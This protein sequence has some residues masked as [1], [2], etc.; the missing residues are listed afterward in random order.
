MLL[1]VGCGTTIDDR[2]R[3]SGW[4]LVPPAADA[5]PV[6]SNE[7]L[8]GIYPVG[9]RILDGSAL[10]GFGPCN[11]FPLDLGEKTWGAKGS[12]SLVAA[13]EE[14][15]AYFKHQGMAVRVVNRTGR[16]V[17][18]LAVDSRLNLIREAKD[19]NGQWR[20]IETMSMTTCG[21]SFHRV[22]L[23]PDQYWEFPA[24]TY[25]GPIH[26]KIRFRLD[27][28]EGKPSI[29]SNEYDGNVTASQMK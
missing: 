15:V 23:G 9:S 4:D 1:T 7:K 11:N 26:T 21:N 3:E 6:E 10:G 24:R 13:A 16:N 14:P 17:K 28:E 2:T 8:P 27:P 20:E 29:Y 18:F 12:V 19:G 5:T 25:A 22:T